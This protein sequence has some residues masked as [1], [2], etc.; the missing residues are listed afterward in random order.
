MKQAKFLLLTLLAVLGYSGARAEYS[1]DFNTAITTSNHDFA[2]AQKWGHIVGTNNY[3][4]MGPYYMSYSYSGTDGVDGTGALV[5]YRQYAGDSGGGAVCYDLLVT[6][7]VSGTITLQVK[8]VSTASSSNNAF[9]EFYATD[10]TTRGDLLETVKEVIPGYNSG[11]NTEWITATLEV[12]EAQKIGIRAQNVYIDNFTATEAV[13]PFEASLS[14][15][16][17][18]N[19]D[20]AT[21]TGGT[22]TYFNQQADGSL[23]VNLKVDLANTGDVDFVSGSTE[24]YTLTLATASYASGTKTYYEDATINVPV[25]LAAGATAENVEVSFTIPYTSGWKYYF[26]RE[27]ITGTTS[28]S[29]RFAGVTAYEPKFLFREA[30][31]TSTS[32]LSGTVDFGMISSETTKNYEIYNDGTAPLFVRSITG[33]T[34]F[35]M[36]VAETTGNDVYINHSSIDAGGVWYAWTWTTADDGKWVKENNGV[37]ADVK[38]N[39]IFLRMDS[40]GA[41]SW[42]DNVVWGRTGDIVVTKGGGY[43]IDGYESGTE[44]FIGG[45][46][47]AL[48]PGKSSVAVDITLPVSTT[49]AYSGNLEVQ[50]LDANSANKTYSLA[51]TGNVLTEGTWFCDFN[52]SKTTSLSASYPAGSVVESSTLYAAAT[53]GYNSYDQYLRSY[54]RRDNNKFITPKL[55]LEAGQT[56]TFDAIKLQSGNYD[57]TVYACSDRV[58]WGTPVL[59]VSNTDSQFASTNTRYTQTITC[60][61]TGDWYFAFDIYGMGLDNI[62]GGTLVPVDHDIF[63]QKVS[64]PHAEGASIKSGE[65]QTK[66]TVTIIPLTTETADAY[67]VKYIY[68][69]NVV[70]GTSKALTASS[71]A[72]TVISVP[73]TPEVESTTTFEGTKVVFEFQDGTK[74]ETEP[75][76]LTVTNEPKFHFVNTMPSSAFNEPTD[77]TTPI[78]FGKTNK[79]DAQSF[80]IYN[81][82]SASLRVKSIAMPE[83][84]SANVTAPLTVASFDASDL[85]ASA[86][87]LDITFSATTAG[88][89]SGDMVI[90]Y[91]DGAGEDA[92]FT[93]AV[94]GTKLDP[95]KWYANFDDGNWPEGST[96]QGSVNKYNANGYGAA[97]YYITSSSTTNNLF[98]TPKLT[99]NAGEKI[100]FDAKYYSSSNTSGKVVVYAAAT[101]DELLDTEVEKTPI[102]TTSGMTT[103]FQTFTVTIPE[104]G[105]YYLGFEISGRPY[106][107]EFYGLTQAETTGLDLALVS[108]NIPTQGMQNVPL[109]A[110][111][112]INNFGAKEVAGE[113]YFVSV[114]LGDLKTTTEAGTVALPMTPL[115]SATGTQVPVQIQS[116]KAGNFA[117]TIMISD[118]EGNEILSTE[119]VE[120]AFTVEEQ[121]SEATAEADGTSTSVPLNLS[122]YNS[123]SVSLYTSSVLTG[124]YGLSAGAKIKS[125]TY[126]G[127]KTSDP[128]TSTL[129][130]WYEWVDETSQAQPANG[131]YDT[132]GMTQIVTDEEKTWEKKGTATA[133]ED[134]ITLTFDEPLEYQAGKALRIVVRSNSTAWKACNFEK[135]T[136]ATSGLAYYHYNDDKNK[137][138]SNSWSSSVLP[139]LHMELEATSTTIEGQVTD[140]AGNPVPYAKVKLVSSDGDD[141]EYEANADADGDYIV[142]VIQSQRDYTVTASAAGYEDATAEVSFAD[143]NVTQN[144]TLTAMPD[145]VEVTIGEHGAASF[146]SKY[147]LD[148]T[149]SD[150]YAYIITGRDGSIFTKE[151]V[152]E[153]PANTGIIVAAAE[154]TYQVAVDKANDAEEIDGNMLEA[155]STG[156]YE[157]SEEDYGTIYGLFYS[158]KQKKVGFQKKKAGYVFGK[159]KSFLRLPAGAN[160][161]EIFFDFTA[162]GIDTI[163]VGDDMNGDTYNL[164]GQKVNR[165]YRGVIIR[166]GRKIIQK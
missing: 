52:G 91:V 136:S 94:S 8:A 50:Y 44:N 104:A 85:S 20:G 55:H 12:A 56:M 103:D 113:D 114:I 89:Y 49:G 71:T 64:W 138:E 147:A 96:Y 51:F 110:T 127:Y 39:I 40:N 36:T 97:N 74:F 58:E 121:Q 153:V 111:L 109:T 101:R 139:V 30:G 33:P 29:S 102:F 7:T 157:V 122:Y 35:D 159:D 66:P 6:P 156:E 65:A 4:N 28:S 42:D 134:F 68:G 48:V 148:F 41:P 21:G 128:I 164:N 107:D 88:I 115:L 84:F 126:K 61:E 116:P 5:A 76:D 129:N 141:V 47:T 137:F 142:Y 16:A 77:Y 10:G 100:Q 32:S 123:E 9:V 166:N 163:A 26:V 155:T 19:I 60:P 24:N 90:T 83:G 119:P 86:Q 53:G 140:E 54:N 82:G 67:T 43:I 143:G 73:F 78:A 117:V 79:A 17:V 15:S 59:T 149:G 72:T 81:W 133:L 63:I 151:R 80:Y 23:L 105:D 25:N 108:Q 132:T 131:L 34:G 38:D 2:V 158:S 118:A 13:L 70:N 27:N 146:S 93:I 45:W 14:V 3:D 87:A 160:A 95:N 165:S 124:S 62:I 1:V 120:I 135:G 75:F 106:V 18:K 154:G 57:I 92:T 37:F 161:S 130:V 31:S 99:A 162:T 150:V 112:N 46:A 144:L 11:N 69:D 145:F 22:T 98:I 152:Y 125:I